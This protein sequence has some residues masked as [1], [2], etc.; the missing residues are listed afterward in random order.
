[1]AMGHSRDLVTR[2]P[3][4][5]QSSHHDWEIAQS[6]HPLA[7][8]RN[9]VT[10]LHGQSPCCHSPDERH[11]RPAR[12]P[13]ARGHGSTRCFAVWPARPLDWL[14]CSRHG[15]R[16]LSRTS[17]GPGCDGQDQKTPRNTSTYAVRTAPWPLLDRV[18]KSS[19]SGRAH[20]LRR[21]LKKTKTSPKKT[22]QRRF[23]EED[24]V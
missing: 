3:L 18:E 15:T 20:A 2:S 23:L 8:S 17:D 4:Q 5:A 1:M 9:L 24:G 6:N 7:Q 13:R 16:W 21:S 22:R 12:E 10:V 19:P 11:A 14:P